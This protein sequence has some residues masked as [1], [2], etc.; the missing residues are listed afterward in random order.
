[1]LNVIFVH[2]CWGR[3]PEIFHI[4]VYANSWLAAVTVYFFIML[5]KHV[6]EHG[7]HLYYIFIFIFKLLKPEIVV[8]SAI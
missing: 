6:N 3:A 4:A 7:L 2:H 5:F 1:M 8:A